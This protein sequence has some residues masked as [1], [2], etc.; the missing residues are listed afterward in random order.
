MKKLVTILLVIAVIAALIPLRAAANTP[1]P[2]FTDFTTTPTT[3]EAGEEITFTISTLDAVNHVFAEV[4]GTWVSASQQTRPAPAAGTR[5]WTLTITP[6]ESQ[7]ITV[8]AN[9]ANNTGGAAAI[10]LYVTVNSVA[11]GEVTINSV[12]TSGN[13][14]T[15][16][17]TITFTILTSNAVEYV[18]TQVDGQWIRATITHTNE[19]TG[20]KTWRLAVQPQAT[21]TL[22]LYANSTFDIGNVR[23]TVAVQVQR[24]APFLQAAPIQTAV[25]TVWT[26]AQST[27]SPQQTAVEN[28]LL[29]RGFHRVGVHVYST[30]NLGGQFTTLTARI[31][32]VGGFI[33]TVGGSISTTF[34]FYGDGQLLRSFT[35]FPGQI[36]PITIDVTNVEQLRIRVAFGSTSTHTWGMA[37]AILQ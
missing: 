36:M 13:S 37:E 28:A 34:H 15:Q 3:V 9:I 23:N 20:E 16:G 1:I 2:A 31:G 22:T 12:R 21:Q 27:F 17:D 5:N 6:R 18:F 25:G 26:E 32:H 8:Y 24:I 19:T 14:I 30:H 35:I 4:D 29:F 7:A 10:T 11:T 33:G